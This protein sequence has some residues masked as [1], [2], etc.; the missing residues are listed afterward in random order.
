MTFRVSLLAFA[1]QGR[2]RP[3]SRA[4]RCIDAQVFRRRPVPASAA[5]SRWNE[6]FRWQRCAAGERSS[7]RRANENWRRSLEGRRVSAPV[8]R[9]GAITHGVRERNRILAPVIAIGMEASSPVTVDRYDR[10]SRL[11]RFREERKQ[12]ETKKKKT[13][14]WRIIRSGNRLYNVRRVYLYAYARYFHP[15]LLS[16][17]DAQERL[18]LTQSYALSS[19]LKLAHFLVATTAQKYLG[20][21][22]A[23]R[24]GRLVPRASVVSTYVRTYTRAHQAYFCTLPARFFMEQSLIVC[25]TSWLNIFKSART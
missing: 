18:R 9:R 8:F 25:A 2:R 22:D 6:D 24:D 21:G 16:S 23:R 11:P 4:H 13:F 10:I 7:P 12:T 20:T 15:V 1:S 17:L 5:L 14:Q 19:R 3:A